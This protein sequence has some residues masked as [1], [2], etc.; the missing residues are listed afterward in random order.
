MLN[1]KIFNC[2]ISAPQVPT[3]RRARPRFKV[4]VD[5]R[6]AMVGSL[7]ATRAVARALRP[8]DL[9][10][11]RGLKPYFDQGTENTLRPRDFDTSRGLKPHFDQGSEN[12]LRP[13]EF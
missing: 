1:C 7:S 5:W 9:D 3:D 13:R 8:R 12:T 11:S 2:K 4:S 10:F 6:R